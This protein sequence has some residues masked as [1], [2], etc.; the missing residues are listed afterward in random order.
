LTYFEV[1]NIPH[2]SFG[3][4]CDTRAMRHDGPNEGADLLV[5]P[6]ELRAA[7]R[8]LGEFLAT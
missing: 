7:A 5:S 1:C 4:Q 8:Q 3:V 2:G 6:D